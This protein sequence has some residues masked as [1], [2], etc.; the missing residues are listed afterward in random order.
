MMTLKEYLVRECATNTASAEGLEKELNDGW[1]ILCGNDPIQKGKIS[2]LN[3]STKIIDVTTYLKS[4]IFVPA[5]NFLSDYSLYVSNGLNCSYCNDTY[6]Y[7]T[8]HLGYT[9]D[10]KII[11]GM[12]ITTT[13]RNVGC[14][15]EGY[16]KPSRKPGFTQWCSFCGE[17]V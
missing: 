14:K 13:P 9:N 17:Y 6:T 12:G 3:I 8:K 4:I 10:I 15:H 2:S 7:F 11:Q 5:Y 16:L 1:V